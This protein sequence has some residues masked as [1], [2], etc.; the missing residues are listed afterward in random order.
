MTKAAL[1]AR[2]YSA[3]PSQSRDGI[4]AF[5]ATGAVSR[6]SRVFVDRKHRT[7]LELEVGYIFKGEL[8]PLSSSQLQCFHGLPKQYYSWGP[9][10][11][12]RE[13][14][15]GC[16]AHHVQTLACPVG[17]NDSSIRYIHPSQSPCPL[18]SHALVTTN[19]LSPLIRSTFQFA[20]VS[21]T[22]Y[23]SFCG[24]INSKTILLLPS[25]H[26]ATCILTGNFLTA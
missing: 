7:G 10:I 8:L 17:Q 12:I 26:P 4:A 23:L 25:Q 15:V 11:Q 1:G 13:P 3:S 16:R 24:V 22:R 19:T 20:H 9:N 5:V 6:A 14:E 18:P 21:K 2:V